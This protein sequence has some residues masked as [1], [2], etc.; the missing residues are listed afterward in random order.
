MTEHLISLGHKRIGF[1]AGPKTHVSAKLRLDGYKDA[2]TAH[3]IP[4]DPQLVAPGEFTL[5]TGRDGAAALLSKDDRPTAIFASNDETAAGVMVAVKEAGLSVPED[6]S[7]CGF[8]DTYAAKFVWPP[9]TTVHQPIFDMAHA[10][11][12]LLLNS[13]KGRENTDIPRTFTHS[14]AIRESTVAPSK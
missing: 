8:D 1:V 12:G 13:L 7:V 11:A 5:E 6:V 9:L 4:F 14:L 3:D 2:L 10:T